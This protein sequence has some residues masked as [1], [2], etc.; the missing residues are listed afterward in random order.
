MFLF[1]VMPFF[2]SNPFPTNSP[3]P[4]SPLVI[5]LMVGVDAKFR[6]LVVDAPCPLHPIPI[7]FS[8][9]SSI[10][11]LHSPPTPPPPLPTLTPSLSLPI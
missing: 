8:L 3:P 11:P 7:S 6:Y 4:P 10:F 1:P 5:L 2:S 9:Y